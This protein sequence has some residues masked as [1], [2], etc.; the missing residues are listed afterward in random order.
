MDPS[1]SLAGVPVQWCEDGHEDS[2]NAVAEVSTSTVMTV[3][4]ERSIGRMMGLVAQTMIASY[5]QVPARQ[6]G[7]E[8]NG[9]HSRYH[10]QEEP[11]PWVSSL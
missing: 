9:G 8:H 6:Q 4:E 3:M 11:T 2:E 10:G 7:C 1:G 5:M